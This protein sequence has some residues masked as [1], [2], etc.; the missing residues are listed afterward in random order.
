M[1][2]H[3]VGVAP[4]D[5]VDDRVVPGGL[6]RALF[7]AHGVVTLAAAVLLVIVPAAIPATIGVDLS[8]SQYVLSY[9]L[10]AAELAIAVLSL[11]ASRLTDRSSL[12][13]I[14][15]VFVIFHTSTAVLEVVYMTFTALSPILLLNVIVRVLASVLFAVAAVSLAR[16]PAR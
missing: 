16:R 5:R 8:T 9:F 1:D 15:C 14:A 3:T 7:V 12:V 11:A 6:V 4:S 2:E 10:A 13:L